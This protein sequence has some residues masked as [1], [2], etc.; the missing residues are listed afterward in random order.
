M[1]GI[2]QW[3]DIKIKTYDNM[4]KIIAAS[5]QSIPCLQPI[6]ISEKNGFIDFTSIFK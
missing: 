3:M 5:L 2:L 6:R 1:R 4:L